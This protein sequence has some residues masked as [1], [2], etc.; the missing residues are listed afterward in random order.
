MHPARLSID[1]LL[2][3]CRFKNQRRSGPGGQHRNKVETAVVVCH[4]PTGLRAEA[5]EKRSQLENRNVAVTRLRL[6]LA[7]NVRSESTGG[8]PPVSQTWRER[9]KDGRLVVSPRHSDF[10]AMIAEALDRVCGLRWDVI[11]AAE[12]LSVTP[13]QLIKLF[14]MHP[15]ALELV[16]AHR[17]EAGQKP[18]K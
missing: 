6:I 13:S 8:D 10:P 15:P 4:Q 11:A 14:K 2:R 12:Q 3:D 17:L 1:Q 16:N 7:V 18:L 9:C 5:N